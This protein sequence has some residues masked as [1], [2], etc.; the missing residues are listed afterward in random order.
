[1]EIKVTGGFLETGLLLPLATEGDEQ[2]VLEPRQLAVA[3]SPCP[4][5]PLREG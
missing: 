1:M 2:S 4:L 5:L 3:A